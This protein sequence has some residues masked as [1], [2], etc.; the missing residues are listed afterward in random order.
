MLTPKGKG[1]ATTLFLNPLVRLIM[2]PYS[3]LIPGP[4]G[5]GSSMYNSLAG[6]RRFATEGVELEDT[7]FALQSELDALERVSEIGAHEAVIFHCARVF[8]V[9]LR[10]AVD[11]ILGERSAT[12]YGSMSRLT[13]IGLLRGK[14]QTTLFHALRRLGNEVRH[15]HRQVVQL[16]AE[17]ALSVASEVLGWHVARQTG[18]DILHHQLDQKD[19]LAELFRLLLDLEKQ[20]DDVA[21]LV[22]FWRGHSQEFNYQTPALSTLV[23]DVLMAHGGEENFNT[24]NEFIQA[25]LA[26]FPDDVRL[27]QLNGWC[28]RQRS[29]LDESIAEL[30][31]LVTPQTTD[32]ESLG[33]LAGTLKRR[34]DDDDFWTGRAQR[35]RDALLKRIAD[36]YRRGWRQSRYTQTYVGI[37]A[38]AMALLSGDSSSASRVAQQVLVL[39]EHRMGKQGVVDGVRWVDYWDQATYA[40][41]NLILGHFDVARANYRDA[42]ATHA[43]KANWHQSSLFQLRLLLNAMGM[44]ASTDSFL[45]HRCGRSE[46]IAAQIKLRPAGDN[47]KAAAALDA[48]RALWHQLDESTVVEIAI[49][50]GA[51]ATLDG[52]LEAIPAQKSRLVI[53]ADDQALNGPIDS[54]WFETCARLIRRQSKWTAATDKWTHPPASVPPIDRM[55]ILSAYTEIKADDMG[56][57]R[58]K[59]LLE[60][61]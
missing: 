25:S 20:G 30:E 17:L 40:E 41:A 35:K 16:D 26:R 55:T 54:R 19:G 13:E 33:L 15:V 22:Q 10:R 5:R 59:A 44:D 2:V 18:A 56:V 57:S 49:D 3:G 6:M 11:D 43:S 46:D 34:W 29:F 38:A 7:G 9:V 39:F 21:P 14:I 53:E 47:G 28:L 32:P 12:I 23:I 58:L 51:L 4:T 50:H 42:M 8:E 61:T 60:N 36:L 27:R 52:W 48:W 24:A 45:A 37:N 31:S 1:R